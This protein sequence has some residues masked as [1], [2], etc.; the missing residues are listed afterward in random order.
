MPHVIV[1]REFG[2]RTLRLETGKYAKQA[3]AAIWAT[4]AETT[5]LAAVVRGSPREGLDFFPLQVDYRERLSA[6][7]KFAGGFRKREG[8]PTQKEVLTMRLID[9]PLRPLFPEG[10]RDEVLIDCWFE[11]AD[12]QNDP[13]RLA[14]LAAAAAVAISAVPFDGPVAT[15]RVGRVDGQPVINPTIAQL[16]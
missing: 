9:R 13:D 16:E 14:G 6:A 5:V 7:G 12:G 1:E 8:A 4:Y 10:M 2:G 11:S 3:D 15:V